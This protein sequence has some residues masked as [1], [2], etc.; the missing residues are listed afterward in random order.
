MNILSVS[1]TGEKQVLDITGELEDLIKKNQFKNGLLN[2]FLKHTSAALSTADLDPGTDKDYIKAAEELIKSSDFNHPHDPTHFPDH[3]LSS[4][5]GV[6]ISIPVKNG[7][8]E[9]GT[10]QRI[11]LFE[12]N[13][14]K[15][16]Q[17]VVTLIKE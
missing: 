9:L 12:F 6:S 17:I 5:I 13:G 11:V 3:F 7:K 4:A 15:E 2:L 16:R 14:P 8:I 1:S 10:W